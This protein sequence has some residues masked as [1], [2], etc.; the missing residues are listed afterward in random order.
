MTILY[1][2]QGLDNESQNA[3]GSKLIQYLN[4]DEFNSF[5][6][7]SAFASAA[8]IKGLSSHINNAKKKFD[9][10]SIIVG[11]D[12]NG[13]SKEALEEIAELDINGFIYYQLEAPIFHP[14]IY[15][16]EGSTRTVLIIGSSNLTSKG[17]F[18]NVEGSL[19]IEFK[20]G[21]KEGEGLIKKLKEYNSRLFD[22]TDP[23]LF[24]ITP[25]I[26][27]SFIEEGVVARETTRIK[28]QGKRRANSSSSL[29]IPPRETTTIPNEFRTIRRSKGTAKTNLVQ[30]SSQGDESIYER[31][32]LVWIRIHLP[33]SSV[34]AV[35]SGT[36]PTGGLRLVQ[37]G[38]VTGGHVI[39]QTT[40]FRN[41]IFG[42]LSWIVIGNNPLVEGTRANFFISVKGEDWG[43]FEL[44]IRHKPSGEAGQHNYTTSISWGYLGRRVSEAN[45][46][47]ARLELYAPSNQNDP[48]ILEII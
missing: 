33:S 27:S 10:I 30:T 1:L 47:N 35:G 43:L 12:Q 22:L 21:D 26:I 3:A 17:L 7:I 9:N 48:F 44:D 8:G 36:N 19:L 29:T 4:D 41:N 38:F 5:F 6:A 18:N 39:D 46:T 45:L 31:G 34:Q 15:L 16:F 14:K 37:D 25:E 2:G 28:Y 32:Q 11:I 13:T 24:K 42:N 23:N 20:S 40:Y